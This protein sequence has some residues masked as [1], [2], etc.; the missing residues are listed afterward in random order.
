M[1]TIYGGK[2]EFNQWEQGQRVTNPKLA[3]GDK[4]RFWN[5][6]GE[7][8]PMIAYKHEGVVVADVPNDLLQH[9]S[10]ILVE[11]CGDP[12]CMSRFVVTAQGKPADYVFVDNTHCAPA[13]SGGVTD[14][15]DLENRPFGS[16]GMKTVDI[17]PETTVEIA[18][19][20][21]N[22]EIAATVPLVEGQTYTVKYNG[23]DYECVCSTMDQD[24]VTFYILG[25]IGAMMGSGDTGEPFIV[26][27]IPDIGT[28]GIIALDGSTS[29]TL[30]VSGE[31]EDIDKMDGKFLPKGTPYIEP[32]DDVILEETVLADAVV[33]DLNI[34]VEYNLP[35]GNIVPGNIYNIVIDGVTY[36]AMAYA[37]TEEGITCML[38]SG[39]VGSSVAHG[40]PHTN[41]P[42]VI[43]V[44]NSTY[45]QT[46]GYNVIA[47]WLDYIAPEKLAIIGGYTVNK[48][49]KW[50]LPDITTPLIVTFKGADD[51]ITADILR[52]EVMCAASCGRPVFA[53]LGGEDN[54]AFVTNMMTGNGTVCFYGYDLDGKSATWIWNSLGI[55]KTTTE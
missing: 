46:L 43:R 51:S 14:Y 36:Q 44:V 55:T 39:I 4:V 22:A 5:Q 29:V 8:H 13:P 45:A 33:K 40:L 48:M 38:G 9:C 18:P 30:S 1:F 50:C 11:L 6:S 19:D 41:D 23:V 24:G 52:E 3:V 42:F 31:V 54:V 12:E 27:S 2:T 26:M 34:R 49:D 7:T 32:F 21:G 20:S 37:T 53:K 17:L 25:N 28:C 15:N 16:N 35:L 47:S 10:P